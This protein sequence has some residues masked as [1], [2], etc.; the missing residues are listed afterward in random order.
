[1]EQTYRY[2]ISG[3]VKYQGENEINDGAFN[4]E[5]VQKTKIKNLDDVKS[6]SRLYEEQQG[7]PKGSVIILFYT[8]FDE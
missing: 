7:F 8:L 4:F 2:F 6:I 1:M 5:L 3:M